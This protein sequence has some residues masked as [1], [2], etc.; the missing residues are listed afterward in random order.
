MS[1]ESKKSGG[2][3]A[4]S[5]KFVAKDKILEVGKFNRKATGGTPVTE[6]RKPGPDKRSK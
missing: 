2:R 5:G 4:T 3:S 6:G 1:R